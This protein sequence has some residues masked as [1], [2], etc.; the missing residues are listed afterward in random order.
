M[1]IINKSLKILPKVSEEWNKKV[2]NKLD[3]RLDNSS[4][5]TIKN[6][7]HSYRQVRKE[8]NYKLT[9]IV[10]KGI[11]RK[12]TYFEKVIRIYNFGV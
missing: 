7:L 4:E 12:T 3:V 5:L 2:R 11:P 1:I 10:Y 6:K 9:Y 8:A